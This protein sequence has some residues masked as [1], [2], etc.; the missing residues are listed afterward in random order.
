MLA[1]DMRYLHPHITDFKADTLHLA[2]MKLHRLNAMSHV[3]PDDWAENM[4]EATKDLH[5]ENAQEAFIH[6]LS[7]P[8]GYERKVELWNAL[9]DFDR[10][11]T[12]K[13]ILEAVQPDP[14]EEHM[15]FETSAVNG[16]T[17]YIHVKHKQPTPIYTIEEDDEKVMP[18]EEINFVIDCEEEKS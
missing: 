17:K 12:D 1:P 14:Y 9:E 13:R 5:D 6:Y 4:M 11:N 18:K 7:N 16:N 15:R 3:S 2:I 10:N 8:A